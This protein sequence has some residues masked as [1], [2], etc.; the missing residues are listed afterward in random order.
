MGWFGDALATIGTGGLYLAG[1]KA[2]EASTDGT[3]RDP[4]GGMLPEYQDD[5]GSYQNPGV[6]QVAPNQ[7]LKNILGQQLGQAK[8]YRSDLSAN[9]D[10]QTGA[11][12]NDARRNLAQNLKQVREDYNSRG[13]LQSGGRQGAEAGARAGT[14]ADIASTGYQIRKGL[15]NNADTLENN[16]FNTAGNYAGLG[17]GMGTAALGGVS[18][19]IQ[20]D[21]ASTQAN[22]ALFSGAGQGLGSLAGTIAAGKR[23]PTSPSTPNYGTVGYSPYQF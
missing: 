5:S 19:G 13:L 23:N 12:A 8:S 7:N 21:I 11:Y 6:T 22:Q 4:S 3:K 17:T 15:L 10:R 20:N 16:A 1:K 2:Y 9:A 18:Q 14:E